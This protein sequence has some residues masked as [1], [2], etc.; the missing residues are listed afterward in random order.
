MT[1]APAAILGVLYRQFG[2]LPE[3]WRHFIVGRTTPAHRVGT[4][5]VVRDGDRFLLARHSYRQGWSLPGGML[6]WSE[7][8]NQTIVREIEE[9][10]GLR[11]VVAAEPYMYWLRRPR[12]VELV[13]ELALADGVAA[14]DASPQSPEI[15]EVRWFI[16][17]DPPALAPKTLDMLAWMD[18]LREGRREQAA[19]L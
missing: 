10:V 9:E 2:R 19:N 15:E 13:Y 6:G 17:S 11:T 4:A 14:E 3:S 5:A 12:R 18:E 8:P 1:G 16:E 7:H